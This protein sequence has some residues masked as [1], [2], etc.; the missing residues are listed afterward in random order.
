MTDPQ[1]PCPGGSKT[2]CDLPAMAQSL[3][4]S[5]KYRFRLADHVY[6][7]AGDP[8]LDLGLLTEAPFRHDPFFQIYGTGDDHDA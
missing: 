4:D 8:N 5:D 2:Y 6:V 7:S 1:R 3:T